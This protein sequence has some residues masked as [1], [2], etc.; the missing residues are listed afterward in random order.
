MVQSLYEQI[1]YIPDWVFLNYTDLEWCLFEGPI[2]I[3]TEKDILHGTNKGHQNSYMR[4]K[5]DHN[6]RFYPRKGGWSITR[7]NEESLIQ[8]DLIEGSSRIDALSPN[9]LKSI[10][11][12]I[13]QSHFINLLKNHNIDFSDH[14]GEKLYI[15][16]RNKEYVFSVF[17]EN[18][19]RNGQT[20]EIKRVYDP[21][22]YLFFSGDMLRGL[23]Y[24]TLYPTS[25]A[26]EA[27][28]VQNLI[29][30]YKEKPL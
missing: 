25:S 10:R 18:G 12:N 11:K 1:S 29:N 8:Q 24:V 17:V 13:K 27:L 6:I 20:Q 4:S 3:N 15:Q 19:G 2:D 28:K 22:K 9:L 5:N 26:H 16:K 23:F 30:N 14:I 7:R 21:K